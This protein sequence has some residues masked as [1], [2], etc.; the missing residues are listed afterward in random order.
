MRAVEGLGLLTASRPGQHAI[1]IDGI[2]NFALYQQQ[3]KQRKKK[4]QENVQS[5]VPSPIPI[6]FGNSTM[7]KIALPMPPLNYIKMVKM[8]TYELFLLRYAL[9]NVRP[10]TNRYVPIHLAFFMLRGTVNAVNIVLLYYGGVSVNLQ[11]N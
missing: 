6:W 3:H 1:I 5:S 4:Q 9:S 11:E 2:M 7:S 8:E 10:L